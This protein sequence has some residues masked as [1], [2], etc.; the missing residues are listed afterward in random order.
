MS[1][2]ITVGASG[3]ASTQRV[4]DLLASPASWPAWAPHM[5]HV[6]D[7]DGSC[8]APSRVHVG[9]RLHVESI[10]PRIGVEVAVI[11]VCEGES[12]TMRATLPVGELVSWHTVSEV[13]DATLVT[14]ALRWTGPRLVGLTLLH[15]YRPVATYAVRR[16]LQLAETEAE[17]AATNRMRMC[18]LPAL[19]R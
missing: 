7:A 5:A 6:R 17:G 11:D 9:Q 19:P 2:R 4:W 8:E 10:L 12:W 13:M 14:I 15:A 1:E 3:A 16:L 18:H